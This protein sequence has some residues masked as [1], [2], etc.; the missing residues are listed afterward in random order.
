MLPAQ[1]PSQNISN[2]TILDLNGNATHPRSTGKVK[3]QLTTREDLS[4]FAVIF[5]LRS[6]WRWSGSW[7]LREYKHRYI[8]GNWS[9]WLHELISSLS[10]TFIPGALTIKEWKEA[11]TLLKNS[12]S[13]QSVIRRWAR[14][15]P[16]WLRLLWTISTSIRLMNRCQFRR[17]KHF[18]SKIRAIVVNTF[19]LFPW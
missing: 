15:K 1:F 10:S 8:R 13:W 5:H 7:S 6:S 9:K 11:S 18:K 19:F 3:N 17:V 12:M 2:P 16:I 4:P 14:S